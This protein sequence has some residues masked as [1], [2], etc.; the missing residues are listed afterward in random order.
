MRSKD[1][2]DEL[3]QYMRLE[4]TVLWQLSKFT[5]ID[6][7][8]KKTNVSRLLISAPMYGSESWVWQKK[9]E[10]RINAVAIRSLRTV[11]RLCTRWIPHNWTDAQ[12]RR[13]TMQRFAGG[14]SMLSSTWLM[15]QLLAPM[16]RSERYFQS[17]PLGIGVN[18]DELPAAGSGHCLA[19]YNRSAETSMFMKDSIGTLL[20][21]VRAAN[22]VLVATVDV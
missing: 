22:G 13:K 7:S 14:A 18:C 15:S 3:N 19:N 12:K 5:L 10:S 9:N 4:L 11:T 8:D 1:S 6:E 20:A 2:F 17:P 16:R 21:V